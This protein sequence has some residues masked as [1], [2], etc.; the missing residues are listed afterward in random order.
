V[1]AP[2]LRIVVTDANV[3]INLVLV[4][5]LALLSKLPNHEFIVPEHVREEISIPEQRA[6]V[7][8]AISNGWLK[9]EVISDLG[10]ITAFTELIASLGRGEAACIA[11]AAK[12]GWYVASDE[13]KRFL[14][15]AE[16]RLGVDRVITTV[17]VLVLAIRAGLITVEE[18]DADKLTLESKRFKPKPSFTSF[19][20]LVR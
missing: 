11:I 19:R 14:R 18:A 16:V 5:R 13:K 3:L 15:E 17:D 8:T 12:E 2:L 10:V 6:A 20:E 9:L 1:N 7:D 4:S